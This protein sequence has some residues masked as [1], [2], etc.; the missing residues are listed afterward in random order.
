MTVRNVFAPAPQPEP[1]NSLKSVTGDVNFLRS[2]ST[3]QRYVSD[4]Y[5]VAPNVCLGSEQKGRLS[6]LWFTFS[7]LV[8]E[9]GDCRRC[10][11]SSE[12]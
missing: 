7:F 4:L 1:A 5:N 6:L 3:C 12:L 9:M 8:A 2:E 10:F 11:D